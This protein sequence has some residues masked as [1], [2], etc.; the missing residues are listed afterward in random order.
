[1]FSCGWLSGRAHAAWLLMLV[2]ELEGKFTVSG[3]TLVPSD[4]QD[5]KKPARFL[6]KRHLFT[7]SGAILHPTRN[8]W[9]SWSRT[10]TWQGNTRYCH[11]EFGCACFQVM[12]GHTAALVT[13]PKSH[14]TC[15]RCAICV[16][17]WQ[18]LQS[19]RWMVSLIGLYKGTSSYGCFYS[20]KP[21]TTTNWM[22][23]MRKNSWVFRAEGRNLQRQLGRRTNREQKGENIQC[24]QVFRHGVHQWK[25]DSNMEPNPKQ[26]CSSIV[27][28]TW[29]LQVL[30]RKVWSLHWTALEFYHQEGG[31]CG[32][33]FGPKQWQSF[34][35]AF[36]S[37]RIQASAHQVFADGGHGAAAAGLLSPLHMFYRK[38]WFGGGYT[39]VL[40]FALSTTRCFY[41]KKHFPYV[42][43]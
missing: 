23:F 12:R 31:Q 40:W 20:T 4:G 37:R 26:Y 5:P 13:T 29:F 8:T 34:C 25:I 30:G 17:G 3:G 41:V 35:S 1:M 27:R 9:P 14:P 42:T 22:K 16:N 10:W 21:W 11:G 2:H 7:F 19:L 36:G 15:M 28:S 39:S 18:S 38:G 32:N 33:C 43:C 6:K 24:L